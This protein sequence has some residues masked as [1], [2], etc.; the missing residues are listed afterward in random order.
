MNDLRIPSL[1]LRT[2]LEFY[3]TDHLS[4][5]YSITVIFD[6]AQLV[7]GAGTARTVIQ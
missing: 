6:V 5:E 2:E 1:S 4:A 3:R 7:S